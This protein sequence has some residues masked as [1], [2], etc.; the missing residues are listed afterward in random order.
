MVGN[1]VAHA[2]SSEH[3]VNKQENTVNIC[4]V[5]INPAPKIN[6]DLVP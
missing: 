5:R 2:P 1:V 3:S 4:I 6:N